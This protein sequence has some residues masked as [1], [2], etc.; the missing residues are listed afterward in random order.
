MSTTGFHLYQKERSQNYN[1]IDRVVKN[2][3]EMGGALFHVYPLRAIVDNNG[4]EADGSL[5]DVT[6]LGNIAD[7]YRD[8]Q[9]GYTRILKLGPRR[10]D[11]APMVL[12]ELV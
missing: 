6:G 10:G 9:G 8:R 12:I 11:S 5:D 2:F 7:K 4:L 3:F 1:Y